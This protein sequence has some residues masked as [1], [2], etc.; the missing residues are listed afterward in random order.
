MN[1]E[2]KE[3]LR[4]FTLLPLSALYGMGVSIRNRLY[5]WKWIKQTSFDIPV[6]C[7]GNLAVGGTGKTPHTEYIVGL[8]RDRFNVAILSRGYKRHTKGFV[9][10]T[11]HS[12]PR[13]IGDEAYQMYHK[14][15]RKIMVAVCEKRVPGIEKILEIN[16]KINLIVLDDGFQHRRVKPDVS[17]LLTEYSK[18]FYNDRLLPYGTLREPVSGVER[19]DMVIV[20]KCPADVKG[21]DYRLHQKGISP[22]PDQD[23]FFTRYCYETLRPVFPAN[24]RP[25][26]IPQLDMLTKDYE[27][28]AVCG[29][30]NPR[31]FIRF[32]K[33]FEPRVKVNIFPDHHEYTRKDMETLKTRFDT[34]P[35]GRRFILTTE[36]DAVRFVNNPYFPHE[37]KPYIFFVPIHV[38]FEEGENSG[39][40]SSLMRRIAN[41]QS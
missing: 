41:K 23:L 11:P 33:N 16:P 30:G 34:M 15:G 38:T 36:K 20:T 14:F 6:I 24:V 25:D 21:I 19:A 4:K 12:T 13:D 2:S 37:L 39:F 18:P 9:L 28:L 26:R 3:M 7:V 32:A 29:I 17:I 31:S 27:I 10:A 40:L 8:L 22:I 35:E 1:S 5:D